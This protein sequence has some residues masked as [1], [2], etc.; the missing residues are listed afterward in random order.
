MDGHGHIAAAGRQRE[1]IA[2]LDLAR[3]IE[4]KA[5]AM[6]MFRRDRQDPESVNENDFPSVSSLGSELPSS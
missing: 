5:I 1:A 4:R 2:S 3:L 6:M